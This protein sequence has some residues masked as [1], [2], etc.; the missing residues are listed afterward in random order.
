MVRTTAQ[1]TKIVRQY[2]EELKKQHIRPDKILLFGSYATGS[3]HPYSDIDL[4]VI[5]KDFRKIKPLNRLEQL[6]LATI[7]LK[8]PIEAIGYTF[9]EI[10]KN[11]KRSIFWEQIKDT[12]K[13]IYSKE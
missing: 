1:I 13:L 12:L 6:S 2:A 7:H 10:E 8:A 4:L 3:A 5:S 11:K 9:E